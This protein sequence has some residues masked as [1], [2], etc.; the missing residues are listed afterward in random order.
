ML[1]WLLFQSLTAIELTLSEYLAASIESSDKLET[2]SYWK[3]EKCHR[4]V[5]NGDHVKFHYTVFL[6]DG[7]WIEDSYNTGPMQAYTGAGL[8][9][10]GLEKGLFGMCTREKRLIHIPADLAGKANES[11]IYNVDLIDAWNSDDE[12]VVLSAKQKSTCAQPVGLGDFVRYQ[13]NISLPNGQILDRVASAQNFVG[14]GE[15]IK[16]LDKN[17]VGMCAG[18]QREILVPPHLA[19]G[20]EGVKDNNI[21]GKSTLVFSIK[22]N[23][24][25]HPNDEAEIITQSEPD[26][27]LKRLKMK[28][29]VRFYGTGKANGDATFWQSSKNDSFALILDGKSHIAGLS[30]LEGSCPGETREILI[31]PHAAYGARNIAAHIPGN[32]VVIFNVTVIDFNTP[33]AEDE[34]TKVTDS[35][36]GHCRK[37][38]SDQI[39]EITFERKHENGTVLEK[40]TNLRTF[41]TDVDFIED[42]LQNGKV[43]CVNE[44]YEVY[45]P[46][47]NITEQN[48]YVEFKVTQKW[49]RLPRGTMWQCSDDVTYDSCLKNIESQGLE[50]EDMLKCF[51][52]CRLQGEPLITK[53]K[54]LDA[55]FDEMDANQNDRIGR[56]EFNNFNQVKPEL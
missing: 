55:I 16:G 53:R 11:L 14:R 31:P 5:S 50:Y 3:P 21:P 6:T 36:D 30:M 19:F 10:D 4:T 26:T 22:V 27:C 1:P 29:Y 47:K 7:T 13:V 2:E 23:E 46:A 39:I 45:Q 43:V 28:D 44:L 49:N 32:S 54:A 33:G 48:N 24:R 35:L 9:I 51:A 40:E 42:F 38:Y 56:R 37:I 20:D 15:M 25:H 8:M 34:L 41:T 18:D 12:V 52:N 17:I